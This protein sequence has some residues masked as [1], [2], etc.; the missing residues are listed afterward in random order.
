MRLVSV[1][2]RDS[3]VDVQPNFLV[4]SHRECAVVAV[5]VGVAAAADDRRHRIDLVHGRQDGEP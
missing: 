5:V 4:V 3:A 1:H 2:V